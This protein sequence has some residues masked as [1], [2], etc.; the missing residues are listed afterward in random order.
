MR[1]GIE[2]N[3]RVATARTPWPL[4]LQSTR[5]GGTL[6]ASEGGFYH[7]GRFATFLDV[8][9]HYDTQFKLNLGDAE[10]RIWSST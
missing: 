9:D 1:G 10:K 2:Q 5:P 3:P 6:V 8:V 4:I 7:D